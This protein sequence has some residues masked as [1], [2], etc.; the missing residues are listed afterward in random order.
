MIDK[1]YYRDIP[2][3]AKPKGNERQGFRGDDAARSS[4]GTS[5]GR[6]DPGGAGRGDTRGDPGRADDRS[7]AAQTAAHQQAVRSAQRDNRIN[8]METFIDRPTFFDTLAGIPSNFRTLSLKNLYDQKMG[9][10]SIS[11]SIFGTI[12]NITNP[13][14]S[15]Y[16]ATDPNF[17][18]YGM[19]GEDLTDID[20]LANAINTAEATGNITQ[21]D[22]EKAFYGPEGK[23][24]TTTVGGD[25]GGIT[26]LPYILP[27]TPQPVEETPVEESSFYQM[28]RR[29][30]G[31]I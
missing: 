11:P 26:T 20:R 9:L 25:G 7:T 15:V 10:K 4:E 22:F 29:N 31:L 21:S 3:L 12:A 5:G 19:T 8:D 30:L 6:A 18:M 2:Q 28:L 14:L 1:G 13:Q 17:D 27:I 16:E 24:D 23:P